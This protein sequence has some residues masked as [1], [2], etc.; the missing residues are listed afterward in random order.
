VVFAIALA[1]RLLA[2]GLF[3]Q[4]PR[5]DLIWN[6]AV[7]WNMVQ[8][9]GFTPSLGPPYVPGV[10]RSP[11]YP[12]F[13][14]AVY[15]IAGHSYR[16]VFVAQAILDAATAALVIQLASL[17]GVAAGAAFA[18]GLAY[19]L[20]P[21][22]AMFTGVLHQDILLTFLWQLTL[23]AALLTASKPI[24]YRSIGLGLAFG[25]VVLTKPFLILLAPVILAALWLGQPSRVALRASTVTAVVSAAAVAPWLLRCYLLFGTFVPLAVG[26]SGTN[27][28]MVA[29][30]AR[31]GHISSVDTYLRDPGPPDDRREYLGGFTDGTALIQ[32][33]RERT[34]VA[35]GLLRGHLGDYVL[36]AVEHAPRLWLTVHAATH[37][38]Y[39][40][41]I[42]LGVSVL[43]LGAGI[44]GMVSARARWRQLLPLYMTVVLTTVVYM[45]YTAEARY[46]LPARPAMIIFGVLAGASL[47][48]RFRQGRRVAAAAA[49][50]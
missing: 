11:G 41:V 16:A 3:A 14:A 49:T 10:F 27:L 23:V 50:S 17:T 5:N 48:R 2:I 15:R 9:H 12:V 39:V 45:P 20:Y 7:A 25:A 38:A 36:T 35:W 46:T 24:L 21:Y 13:A 22:P 44:A 28:L 4:Q 42:G 18:C 33:E 37:A 31:T 29:E 19:G 26:G 8:G 34:R 40:A 1:V 47:V 30:E 6:D 43:V 32:I